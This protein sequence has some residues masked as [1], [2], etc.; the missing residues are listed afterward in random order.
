MM[1]VTRA[2]GSIGI[3]GLYVTADPGS[4]DKAAKSGNLSLRLGLGWAKSHSFHTGQTPVL[5]YNRQLMQALLYDRLPIAKI[6]NAKVLS[7]EDAT[8]GYDEFD[9]G[10]AVKFVLDP[11][12]SIAT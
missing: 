7:L 4:Q 2:A 11:H 1:E 12:G 10:M 6:V 3:P 9:K 8:K 5:K